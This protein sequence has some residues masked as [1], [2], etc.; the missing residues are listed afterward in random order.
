MADLV[1]NDGTSTGIDLAKSPPSGIF[2]VTNDTKPFLECFHGS[3]AQK[4]L[5]FPAPN[6]TIWIPPRPVIS[7]IFK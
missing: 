1:H 6:G 3:K 5:P 4:S 7:M 2:S